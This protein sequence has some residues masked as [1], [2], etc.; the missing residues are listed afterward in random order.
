MLHCVSCFFNI[1][2]YNMDFVNVNRFALLLHHYIPQI[3]PLNMSCVNLLIYRSTLLAN[4]LVVDFYK[5]FLQGSIVIVFF[6]LS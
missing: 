4:I 5:Y 2:Q 6:V 1:S 3:S